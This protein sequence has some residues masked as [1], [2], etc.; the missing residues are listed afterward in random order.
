MDKTDQ[1]TVNHGLSSALRVIEQAAHRETLS[2]AEMRELLGDKGF[3]VLLAILS[4]PSALPIPAAGYSVPFGIVLILLGIQLGMG[5]RT[6]WLPQR[7][8]RW[9]I[10]GS[11]VPRMVAAA[12]KFTTLMECLIRPRLRLFLIG[13][14][15]LWMGILVIFMGLLMCIP[16]PTTNTL[17]AGV[18]FLI[19]VALTEEDGIFA[20]IASLA[21]TLAALLYLGILYVAY[22]FVVVQGGSLSGFK[23]YLKDTL[24]QIW[25]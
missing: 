6:P 1:D 9:H 22:V 18:I 13:P 15:R 24:S 4:L 8:L 2:L 12:R 7:M 17:P 11:L 23:E 3:G 16:I 10:R 21:G 14:G 19:G 20:L 25:G 5:K